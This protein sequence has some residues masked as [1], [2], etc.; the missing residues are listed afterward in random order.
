MKKILAAC[1]AAVALAVAFSGC[2]G[3]KIGEYDALMASVEAGDASPMVDYV[4]DGMVRVKGSD[5]NGKPRDFYIGTV[6]FVLSMMFAGMDVREFFESSE[7]YLTGAE[8]EVYRTLPVNFCA[9]TYDGMVEVVNGMSRLDGKVPYYQGK[10]LERHPLADGYRIADLQELRLAEKK[11][12]VNFNLMETFKA[13]LENLRRS[14]SRELRELLSEDSIE[15]TLGSVVPG[16]NGSLLFDEL[17]GAVTFFDYDIDY[18]RRDP[19]AGSRDGTEKYGFT[20]QALDASGNVVDMDGYVS[21]LSSLM[22]FYVVI[23]ARNFK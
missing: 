18:S 11:G 10:E 5:E 14:G 23:D 20:F 7:F 1:L 12:A 15:K 19:A 17:D 13:E 21:F 9:M 16:L 8:Y 3:K 4:K 6:N 2:G 22:N